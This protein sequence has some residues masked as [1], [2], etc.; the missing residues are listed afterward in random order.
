MNGGRTA[1][2]EGVEAGGEGLKER[3]PEGR[4]E[5]TVCVK[6]T[7]SARGTPGHEGEERGE[8]GRKGHVRGRRGNGT[9]NRAPVLAYQQS[10]TAVE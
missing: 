10:V 2:V 9:K 1:G 8:G 6:R 4:V 7:T 3:R 5:K